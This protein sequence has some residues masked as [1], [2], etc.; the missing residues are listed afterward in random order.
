MVDMRVGVGLT[1]AGV[2][3]DEGVTVAMV[4][5]HAVMTIKSIN[6][7]VLLSS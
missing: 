5:V 6:L 1:L 4:L 7:Y 3:C 2:V